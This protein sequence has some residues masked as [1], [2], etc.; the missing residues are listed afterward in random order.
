MKRRKFILKTGVLSLSPFLPNVNLDNLIIPEEHQRI[1]NK[2]GLPGDSNKMSWGDTTTIFI[3]KVNGIR[4]YMHGLNKNEYYHRECF[5]VKIYKTFTRICQLCKNSFDKVTSRYFRK[6]G[7]ML[8]VC[9]SC[10]EHIC[11]TCDR[12]VDVL[13]PL[14][15]YDVGIGHYE[16]ISGTSEP[17][18]CKKC[19]DNWMKYQTGRADIIKT[20]EKYRDANLTHKLLVEYDR[21]HWTNHGD[22]V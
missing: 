12:R 7:C 14:H 6:Y 13:Y 10:K 5:K 19:Y 22:K 8:D 21:L 16:M 11:D 1:C 3:D 20:N 9:Y 18:L 17:C 2:C 15:S 4:S